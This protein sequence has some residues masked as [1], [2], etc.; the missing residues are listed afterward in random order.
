MKLSGQELQLKMAQI[1]AEFPINNYT[2]IYQYEFG[3]LEEK[4]LSK[5]RSVWNGHKADEAIINNF[6]LL[7]DKLKNS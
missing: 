7:L 6:E 2:A 4:E 3:V 1:R 5:I